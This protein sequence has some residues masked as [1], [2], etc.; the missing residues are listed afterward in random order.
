MLKKRKEKQRMLC[1]RIIAPVTVLASVGVYL[2]M[3]DWSWIC[4]AHDPVYVGPDWGM[5][6]TLCMWDNVGTSCFM[7]VSIFV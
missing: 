5:F 2:G 3:F 7:T 4:I 1:G 6:V